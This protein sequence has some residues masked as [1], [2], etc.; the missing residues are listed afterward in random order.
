MIYFYVI[1]K[2]FH[3]NFNNFILFIRSLVRTDGLPLTSPRAWWDYAWTKMAKFAARLGLTSSTLFFTNPPNSN[4]NRR[5]RVGWTA[6]GGWTWR[7]SED[8]QF[9]IHFDWSG[10][11]LVKLARRVWKTL[12]I[13]F[14]PFRVL[15]L[16]PTLR[17]IKLFQHRNIKTFCFSVRSFIA[18]LWISS[19]SLALLC[20]ALGMRC[21]DTAVFLYGQSKRTTSACKRITVRPVR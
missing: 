17:V 1:T 15:L 21:G 2:W 11:S 13:L 18:P 8:F 4:G 3:V 6:Y 10:K 19:Q 14:L 12:S 20:S 7:W 16:Q 5:Q 9:W